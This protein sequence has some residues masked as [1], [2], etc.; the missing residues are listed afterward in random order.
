MWV[1]QSHAVWILSSSESGGKTIM[2]KEDLYIDYMYSRRIWVVND[3]HTMRHFP[4]H[5]TTVHLRW[6]WSRSGNRKAWKLAYNNLMT[7]PERLMILSWTLGKIEV[8]KLQ[9]SESNNSC[10]DSWEPSWATQ[11]VSRVSKPTASDIR[12]KEKGWRKGRE[13][14]GERIPIAVLLMALHR[15]RAAE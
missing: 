1:Q 10:W 5:T 8:S 2:R 13:L 12:Q 7:E 6:R 4:L 9:P 14:R 3:D 15:M 11:L